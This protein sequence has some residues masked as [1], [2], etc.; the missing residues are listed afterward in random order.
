MSASACTHGGPGFSRANGGD[1][2]AVDPT[3]AVHGGLLALPQPMLVAGSLARLRALRLAWPDDDTLRLLG[4]LPRLAHAPPGPRPRR[5]WR[6]VYCLAAIAA[7]LQPQQPPRGAAL[8]A[9]HSVVL[10]LIAAQAPQALLLAEAQ[11]RQDGAELEA[12]LAGQGLDLA[13]LIIALARHWQL[14]AAL[15]ADYREPS[16]ALREVVPAGLW[17]LHLKRMPPPFALGLMEPTPAQLHALGLGPEGLVTAVAAL[18]EAVD[19]GRRLSRAILEL[20]G[21]G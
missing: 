12:C 15:V 3:Q 18:G 21:A 10:A 20:P 11:A 8:A 19:D 17:L 13:G 14:P 7:R 5:W 16:S 2:P 6:H 4:A 1:T 9:L